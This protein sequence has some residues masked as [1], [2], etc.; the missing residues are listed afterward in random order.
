LVHT[1]SYGKLYLH[2]FDW[3]LGCLKQDSLV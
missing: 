1:K 2:N 3:I